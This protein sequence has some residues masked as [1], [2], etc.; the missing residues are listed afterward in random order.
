MIWKAS[1]A[2]AG[3]SQL[4]CLLML[5]RTIVNRPLS[6]DWHFKV[7]SLSALNLVISSVESLYY[8]SR[9]QHLLYGLV[10]VVLHKQLTSCKV[11]STYSDFSTNRTFRIIF[12]ALKGV[13]A[14][15]VYSSCFIMIFELIP[16]SK[17]PKAAAGISVVVAFS[18]VLGPIFGGAIN[19][20]STWRWIFFFKWVS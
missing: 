8:Y 4:I 11:F 19:R 20:S 10:F 17:I 12:R 9:W 5:V 13:G 3:S 14:A 15:G 7:Y 16:T 2:V 18:L 6:S 1:T